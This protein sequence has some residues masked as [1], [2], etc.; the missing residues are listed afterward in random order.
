MTSSSVKG[1]SDQQSP[2]DAKTP[3]PCEKEE[4]IYKKSKPIAH[5]PPSIDAREAILLA[6][7]LAKENPFN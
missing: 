5:E 6:R 3:R 4:R 7:R 1:R 2:S